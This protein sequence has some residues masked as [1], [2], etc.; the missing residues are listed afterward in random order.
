MD[1]VQQIAGQPAP[2]L[3]SV[4][5]ATKAVVEEAKKGTPVNVREIFGNDDAKLNEF[6]ARQAEAA[7]YTAEARSIR[8]RAAQPRNALMAGIEKLRQHRITLGDV[9]MFLVGGT[10]AWLIYEGLCYFF[11]WDLPRALSDRPTPSKRK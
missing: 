9:T 7:G 2:Q 11:E 3:T 1:Q 8:N 5:Q 6:L 10:G 4:A